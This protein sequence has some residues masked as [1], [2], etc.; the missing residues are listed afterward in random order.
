MLQH[1]TIRNLATI[2]E[3]E[4]EFEDGFSILTGETGAGKSIVIDA[5]MLIRGNRFDANLVRSGTS[6]AEVEAVFTLQDFP[7]TRQTL[8]ESGINAEEELII[9]CIVP[10][11]G[12]PRRFV[13]GVSVTSAFLKS[14]TRPLV[15][16]HG[17]HEHQTLLQVRSH[18]DYLDGFGGLMQQR[19]QVKSQ[20]EDLQ[21]ALKEKKLLRQRLQQRESRIE[22][23]NFL[24][25]ELD[26]LNL[27]PGEAEKLQLE[28]NLLS[29]AEKLHQLLG[30]S[31]NSLHDREGSIIEQ[32]ETLCRNVRDSAALDPGCEK[33]LREFDACLFQMQDLHQH[34][35]KHH[36][37]IEENP[38]RLSWINERM[39]RIQLLQRKHRLEKSEGLIELRKKCGAELEQLQELEGNEQELEVKILKHREEL[40]STSVKLSRERRVQADRLDRRMEGELHA[41]GMEKARFQ[42]RILTCAMDDGDVSWTSTG[43]DEVEFHLSVNPGQELRPL[44]KV[45]SGG[46]LSGIMLAL[47]TVL[48]TM[49]PSAALIFDEVDSGISGRIA[50]IVGHKLRALGRQQQT[51]CVTHLPQIAAFSRHHYV[52]SKKVQQNNTYTDI[53]RLKDDEE[54]T[55][56]VAQLMGGTELSENTIRL[57]REMLAK[58]R[59]D[60]ACT[61]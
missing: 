34:L 41:L 44:I 18:L 48:R 54:K 17:Q 57:A 49:E 56:E 3:L 20:Y 39:S 61:E 26:E 59:A 14:L 53:L 6:S 58:T 2:E 28:A 8:E 32:F 11:K 52:V 35:G 22:E 45:A 15:T 24:T 31:R 27:E 42:T 19:A 51:L 9:R 36:D 37:R 47:K 50:E 21:C 33:L 23:L 38:D 30:E 43:I 5:I 7:E 40:H 25:E 55:R 60:S 13:N 1:L 12:R 29:H 16:I 46:E 4:I 10:S